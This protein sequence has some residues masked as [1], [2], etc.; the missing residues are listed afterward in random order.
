[1]S[2]FNEAHVE[3][4]VAACCDNLEAVAQ[5][6]NSCFESGYQ[7]ALGESKV[8]E[9]D[10]IGPGLDGPGLLVAFEADDHGIVCLIPQTVPLPEWSAAP[11]HSQNSRLQT[12]A[13]EWS[14]AMLPPELESDRFLTSSVPNLVAGLAALEPLESAAVLEL[15]L[16]PADSA[17]DA[18]PAATLYLVWPVAL[19]PLESG[20]AAPDLQP[21]HAPHPQQQ[22]PRAAPSATRANRLLNLPVTIIVRLA[23]KKIE[24]GQLTSLS[25]GA[26]ITF[27]KSCEDLLDLYVNNRRYCRGE[28]VKIGEKFGLKIIDV[29]AESFRE[30]RVMNG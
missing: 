21:A 5:C 18:P 17:Q 9:P 26:L 22:A 19:M 30:K 2:Q 25:P 15:R 24:I 23:E 29:S 20:S 11:S 6:F 12:L 10:E 13:M 1:M 14:R 8:W 27:S 28:A 3:R 7:F 4:V 16:S